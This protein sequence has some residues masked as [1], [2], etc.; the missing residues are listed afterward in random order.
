MRQKT[1]EAVKGLIVGVG[2]GALAGLFI[3]SQCGC[4][5]DWTP[6]DDD[7]GDDYDRG[8]AD[9]S[10]E[11]GGDDAADTIAAVLCDDSCG[12]PLAPD[13][14]C[15]D[16]GTGSGSN[17]CPLGTDCSDCGARYVHLDG[18]VTP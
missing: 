17:S 13:G 7:A 11:D 3:V 1:R 16:G 14:Y 18:D 5:L 6:P 8:E 10:G 12:W 4:V 9:T 2:V 15:N